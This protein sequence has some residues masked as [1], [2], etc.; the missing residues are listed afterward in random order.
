MHC[1]PLIE[2][3]YFHQTAIILK[4]GILKAELNNCPLI[5]VLDINLFNAL[6]TVNMSS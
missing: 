2:S 1:L 5:I 4:F 6:L 3:L